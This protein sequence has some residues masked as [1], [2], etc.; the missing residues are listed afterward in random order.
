MILLYITV[1]SLNLCFQVAFFFA[2]GIEVPLA[3][4]LE[5]LGLEVRGDRIG[6][7]QCLHEDDSC[8]SDNDVSSDEDSEEGSDSNFENNEYPCYEEEVGSSSRF[9]Q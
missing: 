6:K 7:A 4:S 2:S 5:R 3:T 8:D 1:L 9:V